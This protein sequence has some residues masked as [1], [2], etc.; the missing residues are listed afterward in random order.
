MDQNHQLV[1]VSQE[2]Q[3]L[4]FLLM[5]QEVLVVRESRVHYLGVLGV[6]VVQ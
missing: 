6:P 5:V 2:V 1:L 4:Q 3:A